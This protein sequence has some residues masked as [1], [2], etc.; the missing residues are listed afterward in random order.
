[1]K[2]VIL[3]G[4]AI[5]AVGLIAKKYLDSKAKEGY[6]DTGE[7]ILA[8]I[9]EILESIESK[10][11]AISKKV[12]DYLENT[13]FSTLDKIDAMLGGKITN[14]LLS[15][16]DFVDAASNTFDN[17][18]GKSSLFS[19]LDKAGFA[20]NNLAMTLESKYSDEE[21]IRKAYESFQNAYKELQQYNEENPQW[22]EDE[23]KTDSLNDIANLSQAF[24]KCESNI[25]AIIDAVAKSK[26]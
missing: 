11:Q 23:Y 21:A 14:T 6:M 24:N 15:V 3:G 9:G 13:D 25:D 1:M 20:L 18:V 19:P 17:L 10:A 2:K 5:G 7:Y 26:H 8:Q 22:I 12:D 16:G 4:I